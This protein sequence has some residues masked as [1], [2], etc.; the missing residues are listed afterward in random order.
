[1]LLLLF[2][3]LFVCLLLLLLLFIIHR[4]GSGALGHDDDVRSAD[5]IQSNVCTDE[6]VY[7]QIIVDVNILSLSLSLSLYTQQM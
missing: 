2:V 4:V 3:C 1:M 6:A 7:G 5:C